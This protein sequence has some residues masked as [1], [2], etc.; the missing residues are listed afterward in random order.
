V[1]RSDV[2]RKRLFGISETDR[3]PAKAYR[4]EITDRVYRVLAE[5]AARIVAAGHS[6]VVD[7]MFARASE[8]H[9]IAAA[10][11]NAKA[12]FQALFLAADLK[13][14]LARVGARSLDASDADAAIALQQEGYDLGGL[15]WATIDA[16]GSLAE[17]VE[18]AQTAI[19]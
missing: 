5:K 16:S 14:R 19:R 4:A 2:E 3:L 7:A 18:R 9:V 11:S 10:A 17:V 1:L 15:D 8:R 13:T 12:G 6:V